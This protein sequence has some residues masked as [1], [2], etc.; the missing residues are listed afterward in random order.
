M[1]ERLIGITFEAQIQMPTPEQ[2]PV[3]GKN[4]GRAV[5]QLSVKV[6]RVREELQL[7]W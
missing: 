1:V 4:R 5:L 2:P 7:V 3:D 6:Q